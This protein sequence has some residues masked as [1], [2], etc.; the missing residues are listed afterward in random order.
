MDTIVAGVDGSDGSKRALEWA[1]A[2]ARFRHARLE[3]VHAW[4]PPG[5]LYDGLD[6]MGT[7][8]EVRAELRRLAAQQLDET[9]TELAATLDGLDVDRVVVENT[10]AA[11][12]LEAAADADLLVV[13]RRGHGGFAELLL[14]SVSQQCAHHSTCPVTIVPARRE[15]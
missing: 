7:D 15:V 14:G 4:Y 12:L 6:W 5:V 8:D 9:C 3:L 2:E 11:A 10:A 13:G 1:A